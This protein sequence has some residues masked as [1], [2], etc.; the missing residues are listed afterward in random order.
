MEKVDGD[1]DRGH[2]PA[3]S[4]PLVLGKCE[5]FANETTALQ[6][7]FRIRGH[8][9]KMCVKCH[10]EIAGVGVEYTWGKSK[11]QYRRYNDCVAKHMYATIIKSLSTANIPLSTIRKFARRTRAHMRAHLHTQACDS[12]KNVEHLLKQFKAHRCAMEFDLKFIK[13]S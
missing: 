5:D 10:P 4:M 9:L 12:F 8:I 6:E 11:L 1:D 2:D 7:Q 13:E 3:M